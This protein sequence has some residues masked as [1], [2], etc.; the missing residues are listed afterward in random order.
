VTG[1]LL[2][3]AEDLAAARVTAKP[4]AWAFAV[5]A[6]DW[7]LRDCLRCG[8]PLGVYPDGRRRPLHASDRQV[9]CKN[10]CRQAAYRERK[11]DASA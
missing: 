2:N 10:A 7:Q 1:R 6:P 4:N 11:K 3:F 9:Y 8:G 5:T